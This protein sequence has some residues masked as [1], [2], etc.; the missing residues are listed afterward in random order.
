MPS[1][2]GLSATAVVIMYSTTVSRLSA[3]E[4]AISKLH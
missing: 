4:H 3:T 1:A 2:I